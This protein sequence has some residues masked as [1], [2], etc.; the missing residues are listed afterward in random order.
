MTRR[1][2]LFALAA[3]LYAA[4]GAGVALKAARDSAWCHRQ[5][6]PNLPFAAKDVSFVGPLVG[7]P[8]ALPAY[9]ASASHN[10]GRWCWF[11]GKKPRPARPRRVEEEE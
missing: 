11:G 1:S 7:W 8:L 9:L 10:E 2:R 6:W 4:A 3:A 5:A